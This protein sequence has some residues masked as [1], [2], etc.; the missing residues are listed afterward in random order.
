M[1]VLDAEVTP[2]EPPRAALASASQRKIWHRRLAH[3]EDKVVREAL[4]R[5][6]ENYGAVS[7]ESTV[8]CAMCPA[9]KAKKKP[10][11]GTLTHQESKVRSM[12]HSDLANLFRVKTTRGER[13]LASFIDGQSQS[14]TAV[15]LKKK[16]DLYEDFDELR[17]QFE[18]SNDCRIKAIHSDDG[19]EYQGLY[20]RKLKP[21]GILSPRTQRYSPSANGISENWNE[22]TIGRSRMMVLEAEERGGKLPQA[23]WGYA[24]K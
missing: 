11:K 17:V 16:S 3:A 15:L 23:V 5:Q 14:A 4:K 2:S 21:L 7:S 22:N 9:A 12:I 13:Y 10:F 1:N 19:G 20:N 18:R 8:D 24:D 6:E